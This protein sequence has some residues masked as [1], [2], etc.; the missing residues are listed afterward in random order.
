MAIQAGL[1]HMVITTLM[2]IRNFKYQQFQGSQSL[3][4]NKKIIDQ[5]RLGKKK[6][7]DV[8]K[9]TVN[10]IK[11]QLINVSRSCLDFT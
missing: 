9:V 5:Y 6:V 7:D 2:V 10:R 3:P 8:F 11:R 4:D 1:H